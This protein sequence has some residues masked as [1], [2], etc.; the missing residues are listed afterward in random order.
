MSIR[1]KAR[2]LGIALLPLVLWLVLAS[3]T[4]A[5]CSQARVVLWTNH[6]FNGNG[7]QVCYPTNIP[8]LGTYGFD[9]NVSSVQ[10]YHSTPCISVTLWYGYN[11]TGGNQWFRTN[12]QT[13]QYL[14]TPPNDSFSSLS[15]SC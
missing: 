4:A 13:A 3:P 9:N 14:T 12:G 6:G 15:W 5:S 10:F 1:S 7:L 2:A 8:N 11:Y